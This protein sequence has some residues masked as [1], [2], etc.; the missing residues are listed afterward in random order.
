M[1]RFS[2]TQVDLT[3]IIVRRKGVDARKKQKIKFVYTVEFSLSDE[4]GFWRQHHLD[5]DLEVVSAREPPLFRR[6]AGDKRIVIVGTGPAGLFAALRLAEYGLAPI[7]LERG[8]ELR[9][10]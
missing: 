8:G 10:G 7:L 1:A 4:T 3:G 5:R 9:K 6:I 2:L